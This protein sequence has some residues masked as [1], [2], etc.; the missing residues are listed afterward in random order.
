MNS[1]YKIIFDIKF[2]EYNK[3]VK[4]KF[5]RYKQNFKF[6]LWGYGWEW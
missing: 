4:N 5:W 2:V 6:K 3:L 1:F